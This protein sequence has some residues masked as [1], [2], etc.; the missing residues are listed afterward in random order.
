MYN[1]TRGGNMLKKDFLIKE[2]IDKQKSMNQIAKENDIAIGTV[3]NYIKKYEIESRKHL[4]VEAKRKISEKNKGRPSS[5]KGRHLSKETKEKISKAHKG[6]FRNKTEFGGHKKQRQDGYICVYVPNHKNATKEGYVMEHILIME[7]H[8]GRYLKDD[9][10]VHHKNKIRN[11]NRIENLQLMTFKEHAGFHMK[12][13]Q[14]L[15]K[16]GMMTYQ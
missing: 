11:D 15:K 16:K 12:E 6:R 1:I 7:H 5:L 13:R 2:Y 14:R 9:E 3:Y 10:V 4:T 8:I